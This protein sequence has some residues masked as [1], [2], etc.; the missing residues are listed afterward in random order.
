MALV[1]LGPLVNLMGEVRDLLT[2]VRD[3]LAADTTPTPTTEG[4][5]P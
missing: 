2:E 5:H 3:L 4:T 1:D